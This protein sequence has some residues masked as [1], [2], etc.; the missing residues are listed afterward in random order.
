MTASRARRRLISLTSTLPLKHPRDLTLLLR[1]ERWLW[2]HQ[3]TLS[4]QAVF[5]AARDIAGI[6]DMEPRYQAILALVRADIDTGHQLGVIGTPTHFING[7]RLP[8]LPTQDFE[9]AVRHELTAATPD[10]SATTMNR[11]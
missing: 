3:P 8:P 6:T 1:M 5:Q 10:T 11:R 7:V 2:A 4:R 9:T